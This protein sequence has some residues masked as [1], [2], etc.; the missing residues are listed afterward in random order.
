VWPSYSLA[1]ARAEAEIA[2][3]CIERGEEPSTAKAKAKE[4]ASDS[5]NG[6]VGALCDR[7][8]E[9]YLKKNVRRWAAAEGEINNHIRPRIGRN[10]VE[11]IQ[12]ADVRELIAAIEPKAPVAA[13]RALQRLRAI[14]NWALEQDL[15]DRNPTLGI[16]R[17][18]REKSVSRTLSDDEL[19]S[20]W[21]GCDALSYPASQYFR[22]VI[23]TGQRRDEVRMMHWNELDMKRAD[24]VIPEERYKSRRRHLVPMTAGMVSSL[25][26]MPLKD[27]GGYVF[28]V[29]EGETAYANVIKPKRKLDEISGVSGWTI[30]DLRRTLRTGLS[31]LGV[32]PDISE[33][34][35]GHTVGG[36]LGQVY[37]TYEFRDE[38]LTAL[39]QWGE[40]VIEISS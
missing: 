9:E 40:H 33:R 13:N 16:K 24:W 17:P 18:T 7:Y 12:R 6:T 14:F 19:G 39:E 3:R 1:D 8:I 27:A 26:D 37:D 34:V 38:K 29:N 28:S 4:I 10:L 23:L 20:V 21:R 30:H 5:E 31:R 35:I 36:S 32:R 22:F 2:L 15:V 25:K 11:E